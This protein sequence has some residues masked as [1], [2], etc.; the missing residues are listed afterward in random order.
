VLILACAYAPL[1][2]ACTFVESF[3]L[4]D[5]RHVFIGR[6]VSKEPKA[7]DDRTA[8]LLEVEP[9]VE[10]TPEGHRL[11]RNYQ[12][13]PTAVDAACNRFYVYPQPYTEEQYRAGNVVSI[14]G[15]E[16]GPTELGDLAVGTHQIDLIRLSCDG[17]DMT[18]IPSEESFGTACLSGMFHIYRV[19]ALLPTASDDDIDRALRWLS[20]SWYQLPYESLVGKYADP[21][22]AKTYLDLRYGDLLGSDCDER[23]KMLRYS[24]S[25]EEKDENRLYRKRWF[26]YCEERSETVEPA[27]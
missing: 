15:L 20:D 10:F 19:L 16:T 17:V 5:S 21:E 23:P 25:K 1:T 22:K 9:L 18:E 14:Y 13:F 3:S 26:E 8:L 12:L 27:N 24:A 7:H 11:G 4:S 6:I 2:L